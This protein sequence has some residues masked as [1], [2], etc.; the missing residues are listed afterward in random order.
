MRVPCGLALL[1]VLA[2]AGCGGED[3]RVNRAR[4]PAGIN[5]TAA[6][7]GDTIHVS[8]RRFG[9]G[10]IRLLVSNQTDREQAV[11]LETAGN[12]SGVT[13]TTRPIPPAGTGQLQIAVPEG[14]YEIR[15][16][17]RAVRPVTVRVGAQRPSAQNDLLLP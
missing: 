2:L 7:A 5:V 17:D 10:P 1:G 15:V 16:R 6:I 13:G 12:A 9:G 8:P 11:T 3:E 4:P 14:D